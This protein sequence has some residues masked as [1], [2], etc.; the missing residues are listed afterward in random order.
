MYV[1]SYILTTRNSM[2]SSRALDSGPADHIG[3]AR[4]PLSFGLADAVQSFSGHISNVDASNSTTDVVHTLTFKVLHTP[5][6]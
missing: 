6:L 3:H 2:E 1:T 4:L 5:C